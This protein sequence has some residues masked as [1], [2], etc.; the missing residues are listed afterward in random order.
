MPV[1]LTPYLNTPDSVCLEYSGWNFA[2]DGGIDTLGKH[3]IKNTEADPAGFN[4][5]GD[6]HC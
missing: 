2:V 4:V 1:V 3:P 5:H 6:A